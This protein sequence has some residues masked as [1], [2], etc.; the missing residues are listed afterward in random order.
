[1]EGQAG[2]SGLISEQIWDA[3]AIPD[4][5]L[6]PGRPTGSARPLVWAHAEHVKLLRSLTDGRVFDTPP[7]TVERY[8]VN[9]TQAAHAIWRFE[10]QVPRIAAGRTLRIET[11]ARTR[12]RWTADDWA[13]DA[14]L[15]ARD[16]GVG[17]YVVDLPT[18]ALTPGARIS[19]TCY[20]PDAD[21]WEGTNFTIDV[22]AGP[23]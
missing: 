18:T 6:T 21:R 11:R 22:S 13:T 20:W 14:D 9:R 23:R 4:K 5:H 8:I 16:S 19:F 1:M 2:D 10:A 3:G 15:E 17:L 7:Q 12:I